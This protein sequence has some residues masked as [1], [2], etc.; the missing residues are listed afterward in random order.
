MKHRF[1]VGDRVKVIKKFSLG[2]FR[3]QPSMD[4]TIG[5]V[6]TILYISKLKTYYL[7]VS[8]DIGMNWYYIFESLEPEMVIGQQLEFEFMKERVV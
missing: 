4:R 8:K 7:D 6:Y 3:W 2:R 5:K 1:K